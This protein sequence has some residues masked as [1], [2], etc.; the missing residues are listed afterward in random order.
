MEFT[1][2]LKNNASNLPIKENRIRAQKKKNI[3]VL[4]TIQTHQEKERKKKNSYQRIKM[5]LILLKRK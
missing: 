5:N 4:S 1:I 2:S 3:I